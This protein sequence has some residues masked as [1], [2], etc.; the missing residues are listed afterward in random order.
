MKRVLILATLLMVGCGG[1]NQS[2]NK[3][4]EDAGGQK[5]SVQMADGKKLPEMHMVTPKS[6]PIKI[7]VITTEKDAEFIKSKGIIL[8]TEE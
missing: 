1:K 7:D 8:S 3:A 5:L 2:E 4:T 6:A